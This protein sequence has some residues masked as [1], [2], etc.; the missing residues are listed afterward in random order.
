MEASYLKIS[1]VIKSQNNLYNIDEVLSAK[2]VLLKNKLFYSCIL[3]LW[4][5][6]RRRILAYENKVKFNTCQSR[7]THIERRSFTIGFH[8]VSY[9]ITITNASLCPN[10]NIEAN[11]Y[12]CRKADCRIAPY[13]DLSISVDIASR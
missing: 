5:T 11:A 9:L 10:T 8:N 1:F 6:K 2:Y 3:Y 4:L 7:W 12:H 13:T